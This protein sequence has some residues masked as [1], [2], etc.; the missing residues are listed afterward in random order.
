MHATG[1]KISSC[2][3]RWHHCPSRTQRLIPAPTRAIGVS[4]YPFADGPDASVVRET[5]GIQS[6]TSAARSVSEFAAWV[7]DEYGNPACL[8]SSLRVLLSPTANETTSY[9]TSP[10]L[11]QNRLLSQQ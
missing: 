3:V 6:L 7:L 10:A 9:R 2:T 1:P 8:V 5:F 11:V 4:H